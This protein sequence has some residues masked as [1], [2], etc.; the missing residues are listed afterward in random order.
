MTDLSSGD[1]VYTIGMLTHPSNFGYPSLFPG[2]LGEVLTVNGALAR[3]NFSAFG[4]WWVRLEDLHRVGSLVTDNEYESYLE[5][6]IARLEDQVHSLQA[7]LTS[8]LQYNTGARQ[9]RAVARNG[10]H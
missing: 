3:V 9:C 6:E 2:T 7:S 4:V 8:L 10:S 5:A 1:I